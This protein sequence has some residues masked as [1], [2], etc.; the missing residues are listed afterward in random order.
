MEKFVELSDNPDW[1]LWI[2]AIDIREIFLILGNN[3]DI[4]VGLKGRYKQ[5][6]DEQMWPVPPN[7]RLVTL[8]EALQSPATCYEYR[9]WAKR[10]SDHLP[11]KCLN[12]HLYVIAEFTDA[13]DHRVRRLAVPVLD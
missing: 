10:I 8:A 1:N 7:S 13:L 5:T 11:K 9:Y 12:Y 2:V 6:W 3:L 4:I